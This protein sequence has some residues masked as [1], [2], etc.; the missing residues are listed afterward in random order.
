MT[1][2]RTCIDH[3]RECIDNS[4]KRQGTQ[5]AEE[6]GKYGLWSNP[7][8]GYEYPLTTNFESLFIDR[9]EEIE[10][11]SD[12]FVNAFMGK[13]ED[14]AIVGAEGMGARSLVNLFKQYTYTVES[15]EDNYTNKKIKEKLH[16][17]FDLRAKSANEDIL[18]QLKQQIEIATKQKKAM[19]ILSSFDEKSD[20]LNKTS[21]VRMQFR[22]L[23]ELD[24]ISHDI[25]VFFS[26][27]NA[28]AFNFMLD[29]EFASVGIYEKIICVK[30][31]S[32]DQTKDLIKSRLKMFEHTDQ[33][34][35]NLFTDEGIKIIASYSGGIPKF[36]LL[37]SSILLEASIKS[38]RSESLTESFIKSV[39]EEK[40]YYSY[41]IFLDRLKELIPKHWW[42][43]KQG[44]IRT[45]MKIIK[46]AILMKGPCTSTEVGKLIGKSRVAVL[47]NLKKLEKASIISYVESEKDS[48][49][50]PFE[51][52]DFVK[53][54]FEHE[55]IIPE[56]KEK[57]ESEDL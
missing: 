18:A 5:F 23:L 21:T 4:I 22:K 32:T 33:A 9:F 49:K 57:W 25:T 13:G 40:G 48:R 8:V 10:Q 24:R 37:F 47:E 1:S 34:K 50:R 20:L 30:P 26:P 15:E 3:L 39:L 35:V 46:N 6:Y 36:A 51:L 19:L 27:W 55:F 17:I 41:N 28:S 56:I 45:E 2:M 16:E 29:E 52:N 31:L 53:S 7:F 14:I 11:L 54:I 44:K 12:E 38:K 42:E 43:T